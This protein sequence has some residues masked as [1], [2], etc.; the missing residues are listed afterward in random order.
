MPTEVRKARSSYKLLCSVFCVLHYVI[1]QKS[2]EYIYKLLQERRNLSA[3]A[4]GLRLS[5]INPSI[6]SSKD[7]RINDKND[8]VN[9]FAP[10]IMTYLW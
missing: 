4:M 9:H 10:G 7:T 3:L 2:Y 5:F 6:L 8:N 1:V